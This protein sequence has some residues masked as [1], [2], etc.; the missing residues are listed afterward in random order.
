[1]IPYVVYFIK[2]TAVLYRLRYKNIIMPIKY[3]FLGI[4]NWV[5]SKIDE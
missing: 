5:S 4:K 3:T 1:M 2:P